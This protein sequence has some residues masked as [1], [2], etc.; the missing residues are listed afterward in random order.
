[1]NALIYEDFTVRST[2]ARSGYTISP[3]AAPLMS[4]GRSFLEGL[5]VNQRL[6]ESYNAQLIF[7]GRF[8]EVSRLRAPQGAT[9]GALTHIRQTITSQPS[10]QLIWAATGWSYQEWNALLV[11]VSRNFSD[12]EASQFWD[13][14]F[15]PFFAP[16]LHS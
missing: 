13:D 3:R 5:S 2:I 9:A 7:E 11:Y 16:A 1:M 14:I 10:L 6:N 15:H 12:Q 4:A 8:A